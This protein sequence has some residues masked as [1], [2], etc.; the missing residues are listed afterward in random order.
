MNRSRRKPLNKSEFV[1]KQGA[2]PAKEVVARAK[3][4]GIKLTERYVYVIRSSDKAKAKSRGM[5]TVRGR[6]RGRG[7]A[8]GEDRLLRQ[9]IAQLGLRRSREIFEEIERA[10]AA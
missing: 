5:V 6:G 4:A 9:A 7:G 8:G 1:R 3:S 10:V 2:L